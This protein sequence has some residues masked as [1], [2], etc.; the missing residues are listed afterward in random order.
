M[1]C[2]YM[3]ENVERKNLYKKKYKLQKRENITKQTLIFGGHN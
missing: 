2:I 3:D 1:C